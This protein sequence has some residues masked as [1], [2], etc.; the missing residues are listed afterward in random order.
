MLVKKEPAQID[1][2]LLVYNNI[3]HI[4]KSL[5]SIIA[6]DHQNFRILIFDD[7]STDGS[8]EILQDFAQ[9][10]EN[11]TLYAHKKNLG[12]IKNVNFALSKVRAEFFL[13]AC[14]DDEY[15]TNFLTLAARELGMS[16]LSAVLPTT[17]IIYDSISRM[18]SY[19]KIL[20]QD[21]KQ[22]P[23]NTLNK[24]LYRK[25]NEQ[26]CLFWHSLI[27]FDTFK[28]IFPLASEHFIVEEALALYLIA[29]GGVGTVDKTLYVKHQPS[30]PWEERPK[31]TN[32]LIYDWKNSLL[33]VYIWM[34][35]FL[36]VKGR[37]RLAPIFGLLTLIPFLL[38]NKV[39]VNI[40]Q[41]YKLFIGSK[42]E[43]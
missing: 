9:R 33:S 26:Y 22:N 35:I 20:P 3:S 10:N 25:K 29:E 16:S 7:R 12:I 21:L 11:I 17:K 14:P 37:G 39:K 1:V 2:I 15:H 28:K 41:Y 18:A 5:E 6:Q 40:Y 13:W 31:E 30:I 43:L 4:K 27:R 34:K 42:N 8:L 23:L 38:F 19:E 24:V 36:R 32:D